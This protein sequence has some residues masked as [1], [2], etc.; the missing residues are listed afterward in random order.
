M[1]DRGNLVPDGA[2]IGSVP[3][4][5]LMK[6][7]TDLS[8]RIKVPTK[9]FDSRRLAETV[10]GKVDYQGWY[11][12]LLGPQNVE[13]TDYHIHVFWKVKNEDESRIQ[14][15]YHLATNQTKAKHAEPFA[16]DFIEW[17]GTLMDV[18]SVDAHIHAEFEYS[19][20][21]WQS[22]LLTLP[23]KVP[24]ANKLAEIDGIQVKLPLDPEG[25]SG[26]WL[27]LRRRGVLGIQLFA[28][29]KL[30]FKGFRPHRDIDALASVAATLIVEKQP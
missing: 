1:N 10:H 18:E 2:S 20:D 4:S 21:K 14:V 28:D 15:D 6:G 26:L 19:M 16:E 25:V 23:L 13:A 24:Y 12:A 29:R 7:C 27:A 3:Q 11:S 9:S 22:R 17:L 30:V 5:L 8:Y